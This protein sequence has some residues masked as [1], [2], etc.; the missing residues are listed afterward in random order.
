MLEPVKVGGFCFL[1]MTALNYHLYTV[2]PLNNEHFGGIDFVLCR[3]VVHF[4]TLQPLVWCPEMCPLLRRC[5]FF[6]GSF[7]G[8]STVHTGTKL[9]LKKLPDLAKKVDSAEEVAPT[10]CNKDT[11]GQSAGCRS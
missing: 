10:S 6:V 5:P 2:K 1:C 4:W 7:I 3:E 11:M 9:M 8:G